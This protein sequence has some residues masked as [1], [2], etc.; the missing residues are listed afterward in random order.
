MAAPTEFE[1][2]LC[3]LDFSGAE[4]LAA[5][6]RTQVIQRLF[7]FI[8]LCLRLFSTSVVAEIEGAKMEELRRFCEVRDLFWEIKAA[9]FLKY[10]DE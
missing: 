8:C 7:G 6:S 1:F 5:S 9:V 3:Y 2:G 10:K 4:A